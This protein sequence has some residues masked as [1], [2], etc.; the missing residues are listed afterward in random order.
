[1]LKG[2]TLLAYVAGV[3]DGEGTIYIGKHRKVKG[4]YKGPCH[5]ELVVAVSNTQFWLAEF[6]HLQFGGHIDYRMSK[7]NEKPSSRWTIC[8]KE[9]MD[10]LK[11]ILPYL[12]LKRPQTEL[13]I[14]FQGRRNVVGQH[15]TSTQRVL[16]EANYIVMKTMNRKGR[17]IKD[18]RA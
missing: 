18:G 15:L 3:I 2:K 9:A 7:G 11:L 8:A 1:M 14:E 5:W 13:A 17:E 4:S 16:D 10:F 12:Q 6:L